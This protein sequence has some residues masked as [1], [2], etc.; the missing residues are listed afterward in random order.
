MRAG[1]G[2]WVGHCQRGRSEGGRVPSQARARPLV[3]A[4][5]TLIT[6]LLTV[7]GSLMCE[8]RMAQPAAHAA[9]SP[10]GDLEHL[11]SGCGVHCPRGVVPRCHG[12]M[13]L[14]SAPR[15]AVPAC[16]I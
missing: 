15:R 4:H 7:A 5:P 12:P 16:P 6:P 1:D 9:I 13:S 11:M 10:R 2:G 3:A 8:N 14:T